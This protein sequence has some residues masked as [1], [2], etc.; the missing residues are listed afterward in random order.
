VF[1]APA[2]ATAPDEILHV[3]HVSKQFTGSRLFGRKSHIISAVVDVSF[4][5]ARGEVVSIVGETGSGKTTLGSCISGVTRPTTG[6]VLFRGVDVADAPRHKRSEIRRKIQPVFQDPRGSLDPRWSVERS[7]REALD[8]FGDGSARDR[9]EKVAYLMDLVGLPAF[10][11]RRHPHQL[12][13]G[14]QQRVAIAAALALEP[15][16][17]VADEP[18]SALDVSVQAQILNLFDSL[19]ARLGL[20]VVFIS[21]D[22]SVVEHISDRVMVM[23]LGNVVESGR[24][25]QVFDD[26]VHPY[27][28][29]LLNAIPRPDPT[30]RRVPAPLRGEIGGTAN[31]AAGCPFAPRCPEAVPAC[32]SSR[33]VATSFAPGHLAACLVAANAAGTARDVKVAPHRTGPIDVPLTR[34]AF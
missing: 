26:P 3:E 10:L 23:Y 30:A 18:V 14:Q 12:S 33:P 29:A 21:H 7:V 4:N 17:L 16:V 22:L 25:D 2:G 6:R 34:K 28:K 1:T 27:T 15:E 20:A 8:A 13:G 32:S 24:V 31:D 11:A 5:V 19:R 9:R